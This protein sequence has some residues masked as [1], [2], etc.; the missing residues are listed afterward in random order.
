M[1]QLRSVKA[2]DR[3]PSNFAHCRKVNTTER[4]R[5]KV[6]IIESENRRAPFDLSLAPNLPVVRVCDISGIKAA[7]E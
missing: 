6:W 4:R 1:D 7:T 5:S 3:Y 2:F